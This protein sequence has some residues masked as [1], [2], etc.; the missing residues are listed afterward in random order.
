VAVRGVHVALT[1]CDGSGVDSCG[2]YILAARNARRVGPLDEVWRR[3]G[4]AD[5]G[6]WR[7]NGSG[8]DSKRKSTSGVALVYGSVQ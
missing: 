7:A 1:N 8:L 3:A 2:I 6:G 5:V 4:R